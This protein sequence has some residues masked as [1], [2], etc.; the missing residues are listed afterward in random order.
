MHHDVSQHLHARA[1]LKHAEMLVA[2]AFSFVPDV[3]GL[4]VIVF[5]TEHQMVGKVHEA[6]FDEHPPKLPLPNRAAPLSLF[7]MRL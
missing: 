3:F 6:A 2:D 5:G 4:A 1:S 7:S